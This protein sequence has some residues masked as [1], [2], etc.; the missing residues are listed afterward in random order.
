MQFMASNV[1]CCIYYIDGTFEKSFVNFIQIKMMLFDALREVKMPPKMKKKGRP[2][3]QKPLLSDCRKQK[4]KEVL[5]VSPNPSQSLARWKRIGS[6]WNVSQT[7]LMLLLLL[8]VQD[9]CQLITCLVLM[10]YQIQFVMKILIFIAQRNILI[11]LDGMQHQK[12]SI[13]KRKVGGRAFLV[14]STSLKKKVVL[15]VKDA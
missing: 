5:S 4:S 3:E 8:M 10:Q 11:K 7:R 13:K 6:Y 1:N 15:S 2:R 14:T 12:I 9:F